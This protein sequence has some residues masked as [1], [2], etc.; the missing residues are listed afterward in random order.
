[1]KNHIHVKTGHPRLRSDSHE[2]RSTGRLDP[3]ENLRLARPWVDP[4]DPGSSRPALPHPPTYRQK[5]RHLIQPPTT[6]YPRGYNTASMEAV[7]VSNPAF[8]YPSRDGGENLSLYAP[9]RILFH[10]RC[11]LEAQDDDRHIPGFLGS[12]LIHS[13]STPLRY[14]STR[15]RL[16]VGQQK[17]NA[18]TSASHRT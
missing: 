12:G 18:Y 2:A 5:S 1:M 13:P 4:V 9:C 15:P 14:A 3:W 10:H 11:P 6:S 7:T 8:Y 17:D 16:I